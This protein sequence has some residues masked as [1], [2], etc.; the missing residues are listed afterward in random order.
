MGKTFKL[1]AAA[2]GLVLLAA[3]TGSQPP[4]YTTIF[5]HIAEYWPAEQA[6]KEARATKPAAGDAYA[7]AY[8]KYSM[9]HAEFEFTR[10]EDHRDAI[11]HANNAKSG[12][13]QPATI[14]SRKLPGDKVAELTSA[15]NRLT[16]ALASGGAQRDADSAGKAVARFNCWMEQQEENFQ[17]KD[18][19][20]CKD[21]FLAAVAKIEPVAAAASAEMITLQSDVLFDL[22]KDIIKPGFYPALDKV[23]DMMVKDTN[24]RVQVSGHTDTTGTT[25]YN[26]ALSERR[27]KAVSDYL[28]RKGVS[29]DRMTVQ[30]F[31]ETRLAVQ[32]KDGVNEPRNRRV[33]LRQ[34]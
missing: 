17:P 6:M 4:G 14:E 32:T 10:M 25:K 16:A 22:G 12:Q 8:Y 24:L 5:G 18:I 27:A 31:G 2:S 3:C 30:G 13:P 33:E 23:A 19:A 11:Y 29:G 21:Q 9:E 26:Q 7:T 1:S 34:R 20:Y 28:T 15:R